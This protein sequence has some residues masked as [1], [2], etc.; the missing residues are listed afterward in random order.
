MRSNVIGFTLSA[1]L[2]A[3]CFSAEAQQPKKILRIGYVSTTGNPSNPGPNVETF[4]RGLQDLGYTE[5]NNVLIETR[6]IDGKMDR[7]PG[8]VAELLQ[9][10]VDMLVVNGLTPVRVAKQA[11]KTIPIVMV[12]TQDPVATGLIDSLARPGG[13]L[14]GLTSLVRDLSGKRLEL[15]KEVVPRISRAAVL[16]NADEEGAAIALKE[17]EAAALSLK[18]QLQSLGVRAVN[19]DLEGAFQSAA[20]GGATA[21]ITITGSLLSGKAKSI[22]DLAIKNG[23]PSMYESSRYVQAGGFMSY[24]ANEVESY[25]RAAVYVDKI[26]KGAKPADLPVEQP[27]KFEFAINLKTAKQIGLEIPQSVLYRADRVIR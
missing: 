27:T 6:Y 7:T 16:W 9:L 5:G 8:L 4:R 14:T 17:Y 23:L 3:F 13:N 21:L 20:K 1:M 24:A 25:R 19:T 11:T 10:K 2:F 22:A 15:L 12:T 26:L 18:V